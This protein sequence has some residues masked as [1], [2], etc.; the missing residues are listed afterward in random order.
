VGRAD[1]DCV[2]G[3]GVSRARCQGARQKEGGKSLGA[4]SR[5]QVA[6][7]NEGGPKGAPG[8][9][10]R[11]LPP[12]TPPEQLRHPLRI[13]RPGVERHP[14]HGPGGSLLGQ[15]RSS[16]SVVTPPEIQ[17][18]WRDAPDH[19]GHPSRSIPSRR[20][21]APRRC[22][23]CRPGGG[24]PGIRGSPGGCEGAR[25]RPSPAEHHP[26]ADVGSHRDPPRVTV[27][28]LSEPRRIVH[29]PGPHDD[30]VGTPASRSASGPRLVRT[31][32]SDLEL[33]RDL[34]GDAGPRAPGCLPAQCRVQVHHV[35]HR[36]PRSRHPGP[37]PPGPGGRPARPR[38][39]PP[40]AGRTVPP[41]R[42]TA[43]MA[44]KRRQ[45]GIPRSRGHLRPGSS[46]GA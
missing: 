45:P 14:E 35:K 29:G 26:V 39:G 4:R 17:T 46:G 6:S 23:G 15:E 44:V 21:P 10:G 28:E 25:L 24:G 36:N 37:P 18:G 20:P 33:S 8:Q 22:R 19:L 1:L 3:T 38:V 41:F 30:P 40:P 5:A 11:S 42:S 32:A 43:G 12:H 9:S 13:Q 27:G 16:A 2:D 34:A 7:G 31:P